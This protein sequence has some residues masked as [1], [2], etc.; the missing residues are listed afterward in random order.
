MM[1]M[2]WSVAFARETEI[3]AACEVKYNITCTADRRMTQVALLES[4]GS[5]S[6]ANQR[7]FRRAARMATVHKL[8]FTKLIAGEQDNDQACLMYDRVL[9]HLRNLAN[10]L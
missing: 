9:T 2:V 8:S 5:Y 1:T 6:K 3:G 10:D 7:T 4:A